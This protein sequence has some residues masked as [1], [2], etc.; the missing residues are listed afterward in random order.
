MNKNV[1]HLI[2]VNKLTKVDK[3][4]MQY[5]TKDSTK[6]DTNRHKLKRIQNHIME[7]KIICNTVYNRYNI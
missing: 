2:H 1:N 6:V 4:H 5:I 7:Q 3:C